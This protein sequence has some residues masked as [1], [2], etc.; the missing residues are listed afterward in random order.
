MH[1]FGNGLEHLDVNGGGW[2]IVPVVL[3]FI[4]A[5][6]ALWTF[7]ACESE[8]RLEGDARD[9]GTD[10]EGEDRCVH[11]YLVRVED[12]GVFGYRKDR[13]WEPTSERILIR[14][15]SRYTWYIRRGKLLRGTGADLVYLRAFARIPARVVGE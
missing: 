9:N 5:D 2:A 6:D 14:A 7:E 1:T 4:V 15:V 8:G 12:G 10:V 3:E 13:I 11:V